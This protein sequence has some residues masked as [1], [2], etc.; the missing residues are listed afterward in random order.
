M[1]IYLSIPFGNYLY[2]FTSSFL[3]RTEYQCVTFFKVQIIYKKKHKK[4]PTNQGK[5]LTKA[6]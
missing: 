1:R 2:Y 5:Q 3:K 6:Q 4:E